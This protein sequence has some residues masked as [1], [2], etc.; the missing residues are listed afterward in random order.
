MMLLDNTL[1]H[2]GD[3]NPDQWLDRSDILEKDIELMKKAHV[4]CVSLAIFA[5]AALEPE[6]GKYQLDWLRERIDILYQN[7]I[8]T[9]LA[10]PSGARPAWMARKYPEVLRVNEHLVRNRMG[11]RHNHCY[12]SPVYREKVRQL[13]MLLAKE[14]GTHQGVLM[15]HLSNE[16]SGECY[17]PLCQAAFREW[18]QKKYKTLDALN[19]AWWTAFWSHTYTSWDEIEAPVQ[20]G[21]TEMHGLVL[22]WKRFVTDRTVDF[23]KWEKAAVRDAGSN[24]PVTTNLMEFFP[25]LNYFKFKDILDFVSWDSYPMWHKPDKAQQR[26]AAET[27]CFHDLARSILRKPFYLM[28]ST[29]STVNWAE[30][31]K[32]KRPGVHM[33]SSMQAIAHGSNSVQYFQWRKSRGGSEKF[34]G[35]VVDHDGRDDGRVFRDVA[36]V[37]ARLEVLGKLAQTECRPKV[38]I[39]YDWENRWAVEAAWGPRRAGMHY[40]ETVKDHYEAFWKQGIS[41][42][43][44]DMES[45]LSGYALVVAP[46]LY[47]Y[48][49]DIEKK[50]CSFVKNG[51]TLVGTYWS[52][53]VDETDLCMLGGRPGD[54]EEVFGL[55]AD[56]IDALYDGETNSTE[57]DSETYELRELCELVTPTTAEVLCR[58]QKDFYAGKAVLLKNRLDK[59]QSYYLAA[60]PHGDFLLAFYRRLAEETG[61][62]NQLFK[63]LPDGV[64]DSV[65]FGDREIH[66]L[67]NFSGKAQVVIASQTV[68][69]IE[70]GEFYSDKI[71]LEENQVRLIS[72]G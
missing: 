61:I 24:L 5:W 62:A 22:D 44:I 7:G 37:G 71:P 42:D 16:Y 56:E 4:N 72:I 64:T 10:T 63:S 17:C 70:S 8:Y 54:M 18:L 2:G 48:R 58:Y 50:L 68:I 20:H 38:A 67:Q 11:G 43:V 40:E 26:V 33:L 19:H 14:L 15:W 23:C 32:L 35:A 60:R 34:H 29:P 46:M 65:R 12:T 36:Q 41:V 49:A 51:G 3:Y 21:E 39:I 55:R 53:V 30:V 57:L 1:L 69:D 52:G 28:E 47:M 9:I 27:A 59:G 25:H 66:F 6:E 45:D 13:D 31:S